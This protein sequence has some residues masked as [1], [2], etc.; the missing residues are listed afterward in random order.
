MTTF[1][2]DV[3]TEFD[4][5]E[6]LDAHVAR[7]VES[8]LTSFAAYIKHVEVRLSDVNGPRRGAGDKMAAFA[9]TLRPSERVLLAR[10]GTDDIYKSV[11][12]AA[13]RA[14]TAV[15]RFVERLETRRKQA[16]PA[17][18]QTGSRAAAAK[19]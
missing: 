9:V 15:G 12:T 6:T 11:T 13:R 5:S 8:A 3:K 4:R 16:P 2:V 1:T 19:A 14:R 7:R 10:A 18:A 17:A